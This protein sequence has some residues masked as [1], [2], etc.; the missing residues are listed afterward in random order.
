MSS[1]NGTI[2]KIDTAGLTIE[3]SVKVGGALEGMAIVDNKL[4]VA[5]SSH[6]FHVDPNNSSI[7]VVDLTTFTKKKEIAVGFNPTKLVAAPNGE[8]M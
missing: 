3:S 1:Y 4:Y 2:S 5:N 8:V 7:S 6:P